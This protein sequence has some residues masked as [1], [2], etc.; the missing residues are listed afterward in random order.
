MPRL[1]LAVLLAILAAVLL[2]GALPGRAQSQSTPG[3]SMTP[4]TLPDGPGR[5]LVEGT[6][7][8]CH[9]A[10]QITRSS[11]FTREGW[12]ELTWGSLTGPSVDE[13]ETWL[14]AF[15]WQRGAQEGGTM[16]LHAYEGGRELTARVSAPSG[17]I[18]VRLT[19]TS[20]ANSL[21]CLLH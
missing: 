20:A 18:G 3:Q 11:G 13:V 5:D 9:P 4:T 14:R 6:C 17:D 19:A 15:G 1:L 2:A 12:A 8:A 10:S 16:V 7:T 21:A